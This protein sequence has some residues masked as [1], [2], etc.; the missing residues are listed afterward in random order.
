MTS[1]KLFWKLFLIYAA[2][3]LATVIAFAMLVSAWQE[4]QAV[5]EK[6]IRLHNAAVILRR[7]L[8]DDFATPTAN[9][10]TLVPELAQ[11]TKMRL[12]LVRMDGDVLADS[13]ENPAAMENHKNRKELLE[14]AQL[15]EGSSQRLSPTLKVPMLYYAVR[16]DDPAQQPLGMVRVA[17]PLA[18]VQAEISEIEQTLWLVAAGV[19]LCGLV[20]TYFVVGRAL[21]PI[22]TLTTAVNEM[23]AGRYL[24]RVN[25]VGQD[26]L[27]MLGQSFNRMGSEIEARESQLRDAADR[28]SVVLGGMVEGVIAVDDQKRILFA[29]DAAGGLF[30]FDPQE[31]V[32]QRL[33]PDLNPM[34]HQ[35]VQDSFSATNGNSPD[36]RK[37]E[38]NTSVGS[39][40]ALAVNAARLPGVPC[41][42]IVF[43]M[44][45]VTELRRLETL[46]QEFVANVSHELK[47]PLSAI[48]AYAETLRRG[49]LSDP[50]HSR[51]F[52][53][54]IEQQ[55]NRLHD[56]IQDMLSLA[57]IEAGHAPFE[58]TTLDLSKLVP[59]CLEDHADQARAK[60]ITLAMD[61]DQ[62]AVSVRADDEALREILSNLVINAIKY[63]GEGGTVRVG[64]KSG[65]EC[66]TLEVA[67]NGI[68]IPAEHQSRVFERFYR[69]DKARSRELGGTGLGLSIV[70]HLTQMMGGAVSLESQPGMGSTFRVELPAARTT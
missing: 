9:L 6:E 20:M 70:K 46:R 28:M 30:H 52:V 45:D 38:I 42:G 51:R 5:S 21:V 7:Q 22:Q 55:A 1:P 47:T 37:V 64:W 50:T 32:G 12:T 40:R 26:E 31:S 61:T 39:S 33:N 57:R 15:G 49:A 53:T 68:G 18:E 66:V 19:S 16:V 69:V 44:H 11:E 14:A 56:L 2:F 43:V 60:N 10:T 65:P 23:A 4:K 25:I 24:Q 58:I 27:G 34:L 36:V 63:S 29:N 62:P 59:D 17:V 13:E 8:R 67:D 3:Q 54:Q 48:L 41:P 35:L